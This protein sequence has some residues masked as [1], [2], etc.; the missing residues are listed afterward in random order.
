MNVKL[1]PVP[2]KLTIEAP[3]RPSEDPSKVEEALKNIVGGIDFTVI[4]RERDRLTAKTEDPK[5]LFTIYERIRARQS[6]GVARRLL[7]RNTSEDSTWIYF[8][9]QAAYVKIVNICE[10]ETESPLGPIKMTIYTKEPEKIIDWLAPHNPKTL[11]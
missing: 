6:L 7:T 3:L 2:V 4:K 5:G 9:K 10:D 11:S 8:N 1:P